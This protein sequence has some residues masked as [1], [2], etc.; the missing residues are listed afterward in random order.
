M[1]CFCWVV[2]DFFCGVVLDSEAKM[3]KS[4]SGLGL[5]GDPTLLSDP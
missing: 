3:R 4:K 1:W 2:L 5:R